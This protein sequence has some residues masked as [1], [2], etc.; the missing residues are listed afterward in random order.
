MADH[1]TTPTFTA[2]E[3]RHIADE[4]SD[5][6]TRHST[7]ADVALFAASLVEENARL[8]AHDADCRCVPK[9]REKYHS[10]AVLAADELDAAL[11]GQV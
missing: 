7:E 3:L 6:G 9:W 4:E 5:G 10:S 8:T 11:K 2:E 1:V